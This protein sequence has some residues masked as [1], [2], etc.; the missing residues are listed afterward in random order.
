MKKEWMAICIDY[1]E[2]NYSRRRCSQ[3]MARVL[4]RAVVMII[5]QVLRDIA[6]PE[7][8]IRKVSGMLR[9]VVYLDS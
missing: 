8:Y 6:E 2:R 4:G 5:S 7:C 9:K 3:D 1:C